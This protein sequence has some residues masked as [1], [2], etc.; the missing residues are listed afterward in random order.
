[1]TEI[2]IANAVQIAATL[3]VTLI[4]VLGTWLTAKIA[5]R[6][7]LANISA[8]TNE[9]VRAAQLTVLELQQTTVE[10]MKAASEDGKLTAAEIEHLGALL[11][12]KALAQMS[13]PAKKLLTA[14]G[15]DLTAVIKGAGEAMVQQ[16]K[17]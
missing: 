3:M 12:E 5:K 7:E 1:M 4:G 15:V 14:A 17:K 13:D 2:I 6:T 9:A 11:L 16:M 8:A 10:A